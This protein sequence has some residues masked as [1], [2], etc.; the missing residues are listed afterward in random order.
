MNAVK[1][2]IIEAITVMNDTDASSVWDFI[3][4]RFQAHSWN[5]IKE[6]KPDEWDLEMLQ[7]I[8]SDPECHEFI[9]SEEAM[10]ELGL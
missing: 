4:N 10:K 5:D 6:V 9:S 8:A 7:E 2:K 3:V 1:E